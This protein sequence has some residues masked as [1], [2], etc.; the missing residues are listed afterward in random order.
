MRYLLPNGQYIGSYQPFTF[1]DVQYPANWFQLATDE[2]K[3]RLG[4]VPVVEANERADDRFY[5]VSETLEGAVITYVNTPKDL[6]QLKAGEVSKVNA[7]A[8]SMLLSTDFMDFRPNYTPPQGWLEWREAV[9]SVCH[10][11]KVAINACGTVEELMTLPAIQW[12]N[13]PNYIEPVI[14]QVTPLGTP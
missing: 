10:D 6:T 13:D 1:N 8:Y 9:R 12:P 2:D 4:A 5:N 3:L 11:A 14:E 7:T